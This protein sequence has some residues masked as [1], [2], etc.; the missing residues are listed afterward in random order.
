MLT[1][2]WLKFHVC[3]VSIVATDALMLKHQAISIH[4]ADGLVFTMNFAGPLLYKKT[5]ISMGHS[6]K[7]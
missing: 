7:I 2:K 6:V 4:T 3:I 5:F 1:H